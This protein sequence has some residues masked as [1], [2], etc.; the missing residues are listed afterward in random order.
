[1]TGDLAG[2]R[3]VITA[4]GLPAHLA[5][6]DQVT[7]TIPAAALVDSFLNQPAQNYTLSF[8]WPAADAV[9]ADLAAPVIQ[10]VTLRQGTLEVEVSSEP[11][12][13]A[14]AAAIQLD[15]APLAWTLAAD[16]YTL[17]STTQV[18]PGAHTLTVATT[19]T[20]L[21]GRV[22]A[23]PLSQSFTAAQQD[24]QALYAAADPHQVSGSTVGNLFGY[25]GLPRDPETGL[26]YFRNRYYDP[27]LGRFITADPKGYT[28]GPSMYAFEMD[29]PA[30]GSDPMGTCDRGQSFDDCLAA[31]DA[32]HQAVLQE[33]AKQQKPIG[34][35]FVDWFSSTGVGKAVQKGTEWV[36]EKVDQA[37]HGVGDWAGRQAQK[38]GGSSTPPSEQI[39]QLAKDHEIDPNTCAS[40]MDC[41]PL[42]RAAQQQAAEIANKAATEATKQAI[43][44]AGGAIGGKVFDLVPSAFRR[45]VAAAFRGGDAV[46]ETLSADLTVYRHWGGSAGESGFWYSPK[47]YSSSGRARRFLALPD[48]N[49]AEN[50]TAFRIPSGTTIVHGKVASQV[51]RSGF[52]SYA[53]GGGTQIYLSDP[54]VAVKIPMP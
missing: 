15:G 9:V 17:T 1:L 53:T 40:G 46:A 51:G 36:A 30:N 8:S 29:D 10:R 14:A 35:R 38:I 6:G 49:T 2:R 23:A 4:A 18:A 12:Q 48:A 33:Q 22:L 43:L 45:G 16:H 25:Q 24:T 54:S 50:V 52:G 5:V 37:S 7:L 19:L 44:Q 13:T 42:K 27:E 3:L 21:G 11:N 20:D 32:R 26:I 28:D 41:G 31:E 47:P 39:K 34:N